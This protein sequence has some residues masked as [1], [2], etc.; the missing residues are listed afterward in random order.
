MEYPL[1]DPTAGYIR[2]RANKPVKTRSVSMTNAI[3]CGWF[4][5]TG[6]PLIEYALNMD[7]LPSGKFW[8]WISKVR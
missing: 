3:R 6:F 7:V 4:I 8:L 1:I 5:R 2:S